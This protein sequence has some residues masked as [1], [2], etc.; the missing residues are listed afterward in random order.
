MLL[1]LFKIQNLWNLINVL[2]YIYMSL[3]IFQNLMGPKS[4]CDIP[5]GITQ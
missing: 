1:T 4:S 3:M 2:I 5:S